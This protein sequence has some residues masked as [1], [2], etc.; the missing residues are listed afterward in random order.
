M[1]KVLQRRLFACGA[2]LTAVLVAGFIAIS[3]NSDSL[4][5]EPGD[6]SAAAQ[7]TKDSLEFVR[8]VD[9]IRLADELRNEEIADSIRI[10]DSIAIAIVLDSLKKVDDAA[11]IRMVDSIRIVTAYL[12]E[13]ER[14][15]D[16][17]KT[18]ERAKWVADS[19]ELAVKIN[20]AESLA[21]SER[22]K[23]SLRVMDSTRLA[24]DS[25]KRAQDSIANTIQNQATIN[26]FPSQARAV[27]GSGYD[28][29]GEYA[30]QG[31]MRSPI[32][33][34]NKLAL[35]A[36]RIVKDDGAVQY[37]GRTIEGNDVKTY[38]EKLSRE[39]T[40]TASAKASWGWGK[41]SFSGQTKK[42]FG[43]ETAGSNQRAFVTTSA[44]VVN[45]G[46]RITNM[47]EITNFLSESFLNDLRNNKSAEY[48]V[49]TYGT[50]AVM[51]GKF[52]GR[53]DYNMSV[54]KVDFA[55]SATSSYSVS[56][57][58][59]A[60]AWTV[61][62]SVS[63]AAQ[64]SH[65]KAEAIQSSL[66]NINVQSVGGS[67]SFSAGIHIGGISAAEWAAWVESINEGN[68]TLCDFYPNGLRLISEFVPDEF[69]QKRNEID[70]YIQN[71]LDRMGIATHTEIRLSP[72]AQELN[73]GFVR[74]GTKGELLTNGD[75]NMNPNKNNND[76]YKWTVT[77]DD[78]Y[79]AD[80][81]TP[82]CGTYKT[83]MVAVTY[84]IEE[85]KGD[86]TTYTMKDVW[87][88][89][90]G[91]R[92][93]VGI[94]H[95]Y[96]AERHYGYVPHASHANPYGPIALPGPIVT[97]VTV[98]AGSSSYNVGYAITGKFMLYEKFDIAPNSSGKRL[99]LS[100]R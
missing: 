17:I 23:E 6:L 60:S 62:A 48:I 40:V 95:N 29:T 93:I 1:L 51:G 77:I 70:N 79:L 67:P 74:G 41:A 91:E 80:P 12:K 34:F 55:S 96:K 7:K 71:Y 73:T 54:E 65:E 58:I 94:H 42:A 72:I 2:F 69:S 9:S 82:K 81:R 35:S 4:S 31:E 66:S 24:N 56:A 44:M 50:H 53:L 14:V 49:E 30:N 76:L 98:K 39:V 57:N 13:K 84:V 32:L 100:S 87:P 5:P 15:A 37:Y 63:T 52:G 68:Q 38:Q 99:N 20:L 10:A 8:L 27:I 36:G 92:Q 19:T 22:L 43:T 85:N 75:A 83:L 64:G 78:A 88:I 47:S 25:I 89:N 61:S 46:Y 21:E 18:A 45:K 86:N 26:S 11:Y 90:L 28:I 59:S 97:S 33:D 16:S 3:C